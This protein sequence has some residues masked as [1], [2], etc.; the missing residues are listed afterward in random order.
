LL[1][2]GIA[3]Q[4]GNR[5]QGKGAAAERLKFEPQLFQLAEMVGKLRRLAKFEFQHGWEQQRLPATR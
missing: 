5:L 2:P 4:T 1:S 3:K